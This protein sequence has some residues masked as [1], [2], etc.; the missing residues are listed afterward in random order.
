MKQMFESATL[1]MTS[2]YLLILMTISILFSVII[3]QISTHEL[4]SNL[5]N[6]QI[7]FER[8][9]N[10]YQ[11]SS[12]L[13]AFRDIQAAETKAALFIALMYT[14]LIILGFAGV[15]SYLL[16]RH[17]LKPIEESHEAEARF[18]SNA[19]HELRTPLAVMKS[20]LE[21]ALR[22][23][24][25]TKQELRE[26][27]ESNL[28]EVDRLSAL[29][30]MLLKLSRN[31]IDND[32][33]STVNIVPI[34]QKI[35]SLHKNYDRKFN[36]NI[37]KQLRIERGNS[38]ALSELLMIVLD[39]ACR[40]SPHGSSIETY[41]AE[42]NNDITIKISNEGPG[43]SIDDLPHVFERFYRGDKSHT[44]ATDKQGYGLGLSLA[45]QIVELHNG[46]IKIDS[47][48]NQ[49][50]VVTITLP[51]STKNLLFSENSQL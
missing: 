23:S 2:W 16:A 13:G 7:R 34:I 39:N 3:Y 49:H 19:S 31:Q 32:D 29:S 11:G 26:V 14:N 18:T 6:F 41:A 38:S 44:S 27:L 25:I 5:T 28:E 36:M 42:K 45:K 1:K 24:S 47:T 20:E 37:P 43:I 50:T 12:Q 4:D 10:N 21:V 48:P 51:K 46:Q 22:D 40:Y 9:F 8:R 17:T 15:V 30:Q 33:F 35:T